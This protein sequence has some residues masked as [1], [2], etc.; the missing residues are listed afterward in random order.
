MLRDSD[1]LGK[2]LDLN[3]D[4]PH[5][6]GASSESGWMLLALVCIAVAIGM[7]IGWKS[8]LWWCGGAP[9]PTKQAVVAGTK[10]KQP[11]RMT[12]STQSQV[13]Y[14][15]GASVPRFIPLQDYAHGCWETG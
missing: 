6:G 1:A 5:G 8:A 4:S 12:K 14:S 9:S 13:R 11:R 15:W 7:L 3:V 2:C 10:S